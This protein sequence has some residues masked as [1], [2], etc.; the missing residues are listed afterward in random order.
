[1]SRSRPGSFFHY[2]AGNDW[3]ELDIN[4]LPSD[5]LVGDYEFEYDPT[6]TNRWEPVSIRLNAIALLFGE[7][8]LHYRKRQPKAPS[9][10]EIMAKWWLIDDQWKRIE[11]YDVITREYFVGKWWKGFAFRDLESA[12][13]PPENK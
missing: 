11:S 12:E 8:K 4:N 9:H 3:K 7:Y 2:A 6:E 10:E 1:M 5:I 13:I